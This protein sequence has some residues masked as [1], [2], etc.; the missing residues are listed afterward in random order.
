MESTLKLLPFYSKI[1]EIVIILDHIC[2][3]YEV[4]STED[5]PVWF[6]LLL[7]SLEFSSDL[8]IFENL[9]ILYNFF[10]LEEKYK[11][12]KKLQ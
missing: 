10:Y 2:K 12:I 5:F 8:I 3:T 7:K 1:F 6:Q 11:N 4:K 9:Q